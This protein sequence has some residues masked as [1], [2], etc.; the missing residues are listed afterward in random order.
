M[1]LA[2]AAA[3]TGTR[4][5]ALAGRRAVVTGGGT[6]IGAAVALALARAGAE[7]AIA[8]RREEPLR[9]AARAHPRLRPAVCDAASPEDCARVVA[10]AD[11]VVAN[12]GAAMSKPFH[13]ME[14]A[15]LRA[16]LDANLLTVFETF[17]AALPAMRERGAGR[18]VA[19][20]STASLRGDAYVSGYAAAKH[21]V[22]GLVR[23]LA[24]EVAREG[25]TVNAVCPSYTETPMLRRTVATIVARTG[26]SEAEAEA[27]LLARNP[28]G[29][30]VRPEEVA[31]AVLWLAGDGAAA[32][33]GQAISLSGGEVQG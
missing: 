13:R 15:D 3:G 12:A 14:A 7:V 20:A 27:P 1:A 26:R 18:L 8:G 32:V 23:S 6:G 33:T 31:D 10:G 17:R 9:E 4:G 30:F 25:I 21:A 16:M 19:I 28:L 29:R 2:Q 5:E 22:L 11:I 24:V